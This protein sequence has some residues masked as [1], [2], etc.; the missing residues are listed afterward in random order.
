MAYTQQK[1]QL[2][3]EFIREN[4]AENSKKTSQIFDNRPKYR[5][6]SFVD[7]AF[8]LTSL[9]FATKDRKKAL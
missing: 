4:I 8:R 2:I 6:L 3:K 5:T 1:R 7:E 9:R